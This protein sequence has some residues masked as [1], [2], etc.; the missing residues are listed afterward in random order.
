MAFA[1]LLIYHDIVKH[2]ESLLFIDVYEVTNVEMIKEFLAPN[3]Y[4]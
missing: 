3:I 4:D 2:P 1:I